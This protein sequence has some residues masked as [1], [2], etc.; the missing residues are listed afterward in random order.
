MNEKKNEFTEFDSLE[1]LVVVLKKI[2]S[3]EKLKDNMT[4]P[5]SWVTPYEDFDFWGGINLCT[6]FFW[7]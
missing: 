6:T 2:A 7:K 4:M 1:E 3:E 5:F